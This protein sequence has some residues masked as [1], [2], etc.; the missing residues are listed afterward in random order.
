MQIALLENELLQAGPFADGAG[1]KFRDQDSLGAQM[2][3]ATN[4]MFGQ[5]ALGYVTLS[6]NEMGKSASVVPEIAEHSQ[7]GSQLSI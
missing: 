5:T 7:G 6:M 2:P 4:T 3:A 1:R